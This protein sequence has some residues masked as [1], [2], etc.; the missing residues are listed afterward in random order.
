MHNAKWIIEKIIMRSL[1]HHHEVIG[2]ETVSGDDSNLGNGSSCH[3]RHELAVC[4]ESAPQSIAWKK[5]RRCDV[6]V[7]TIFTPQMRN[8]D[9]LMC[10]G[11]R[12]PA[13]SLLTDF[14]TRQTVHEMYKSSTRLN[15]QEC[16]LFLAVE[17]RVVSP[18]QSCAETREVQIVVYTTARSVRPSM[19]PV[20]QSPRCSPTLRLNACKQGELDKN[21]SQFRTQHS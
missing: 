8:C 14:S 4:H 20:R 7:V 17:R 16:D 5:R 19:P 1:S 21:C 9:Q 10:K 18:E 3:W 11:E 2:S 6:T 12:S 15:C 13:H